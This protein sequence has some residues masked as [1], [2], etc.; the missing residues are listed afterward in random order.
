MYVKL[1]NNQ[2]IQA[3]KNKDGITPL[4]NAVMKSGFKIIKYLIES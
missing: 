4:L 2:I 1:I 3:P